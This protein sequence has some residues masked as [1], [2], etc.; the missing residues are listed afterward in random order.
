LDIVYSCLVVITLCTWSVLH[1]NV[2][3]QVTPAGRRQKLARG[4]FRTLKK[5]KWMAIN[6]VAPEWPFAQAV[7]GLIS[8]CRLQKKFDDYSGDWDPKDRASWTR[9]HTQLANM[10]GF[11][12]RFDRTTHAAEQLE[13]A[14]CVVDKYCCNRRYFVGTVGTMY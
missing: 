2:P 7:T 1:L 9:S 6:I 4:L 14:Q 13:D 3:V 10:G 12:I 11:V 8:E 5:L